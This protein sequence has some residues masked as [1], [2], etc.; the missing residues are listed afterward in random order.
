[1][2]VMTWESFVGTAVTRSRVCQVSSSSQVS[3][4]PA[5]VSS[6]FFGSGSVQVQ[7]DFTQT[8]RRFRRVDP[9]PLV[10]ARTSVVACN[11]AAAAAG[12]CRTPAL[13][14]LPTLRKLLSTSAPR[15][16]VGSGTS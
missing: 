14:V 7:S 12:C 1:M 8:E 4:L 16:P 13:A 11:A 3:V 5:D 10:R 2:V 6:R 9:H 15:P